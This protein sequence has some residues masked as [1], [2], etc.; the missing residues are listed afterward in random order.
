P[1]ARALG[2]LPAGR[3]VPGTAS[4]FGRAEPIRPALSLH[5]PLGGGSPLDTSSIYTLIHHPE[6]Q[7]GVFFPRGGTGALIAA[8]VRLY[9]EL[10]GELRL[11]CP[12]QRITLDGGV[13]RIDSR[14]GEGEPFDAVI[15][16]AD[17]HHTYARLYQGQPG[18][19]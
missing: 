19:L 5:G 1:V 16:N 14:A 2:R 7:W 6:R 8:M 9:R 10:G 4:R 12:V 3:S 11:D 17:V 18:A 13:H 15:S